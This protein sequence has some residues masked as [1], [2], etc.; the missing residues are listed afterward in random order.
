VLLS[1]GFRNGFWLSVFW[2]A[3]G[4]KAKTPQVAMKGLVFWPC[5]LRRQSQKTI[6]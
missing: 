2:E 1:D 5:R 6:L 3:W 4:T